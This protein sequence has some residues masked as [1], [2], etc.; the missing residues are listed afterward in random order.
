[1]KV[2]RINAT[3]LPTNNTHVKYLY[4]YCSDLMNKYKFGGVFTNEQIKFNSAPA[5]VLEALKA[6]KINYIV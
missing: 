6:L 5:E 1:M 2:P 4:N 3:I